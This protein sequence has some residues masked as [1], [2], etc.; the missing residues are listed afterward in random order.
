MKGFSHLKILQR[1]VDASN[2]GELK[3]SHFHVRAKHSEASQQRW[4][5]IDGVETEY[6]SGT[7]N[8]L[9]ANECHPSRMRVLRLL[10]YLAWRIYACWINTRAHYSPHAL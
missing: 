1:L 8:Q 4:A 3:S 5:E 2:S 6:T 10:P 9:T 7:L